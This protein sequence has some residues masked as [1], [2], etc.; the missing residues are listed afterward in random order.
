MNI[1]VDTMKHV[2][3]IFRVCYVIYFGFLLWLFFDLEDCGDMFFLK[4][5]DF[6]RSTRH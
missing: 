4:S 3:S 6:Q 5:V 1:K 2:G